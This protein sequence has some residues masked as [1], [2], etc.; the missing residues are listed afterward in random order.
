MKPQIIAESAMRAMIFARDGAS[1]DSTPIWIP[2]EPRFANPQIA[3]DAIVYERSESGFALAVISRS[4]VYATNSFSTSFVA[5]SS[6]TRRISLRG[7]QA[8]SHR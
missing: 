1:A 7:P 3:Y 8:V 5:S 6:A 2:S 4:S